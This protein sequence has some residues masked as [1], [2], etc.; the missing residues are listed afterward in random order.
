MIHETSIV[1]YALPKLMSQLQISGLSVWYP[2]PV[3]QFRMMI[4]LP[5]HDMKKNKNNT[6]FGV[7][8]G[9]GAFFEPNSLFLVSLNHK[10]D[11]SRTLGS[12]VLWEAGGEELPVIICVMQGKP[13]SPSDKL[14]WC[15]W[16]LPR[17]GSW[18]G[19]KSQIYLR[20]Q[21]KWLF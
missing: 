12:A 21:L 7:G 15:G 2:F 3:F 20:Q 14:R 16:V 5:K 18:M 9:Q 8:D 10:T 6:F 1:Q 17:Y 11:K 13:G 19:W 4:F